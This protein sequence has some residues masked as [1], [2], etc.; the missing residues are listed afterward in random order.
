MKNTS[1]TFEEALMDAVRFYGENTERRSCD[2]NNRFYLSNSGKKCAVGRLIKEEHEEFFRIFDNE[3]VCGSFEAVVHAYQ[4]LEAINGRTL[5]E[6]EAVGELTIVGDATLMDINFLQNFHDEDPNWDENGLT[7]FGVQ[8]IGEYR[9]DL[10]E[11]VVKYT[12]KEEF[13]HQ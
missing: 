8:T 13:L 12:Q 9:P 5:S 6:N 11:K 2:G 10:L 1:I 7:P 3:D 4:R